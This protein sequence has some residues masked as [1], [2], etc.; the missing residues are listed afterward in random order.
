MINLNPFINLI[1]SALSIY[2]FLLLVYVILQLLF[3]FKIINPYSQFVQAVNRFLIRIIEP[4]LTRMRKYIP[5]MGGIDIAVIVLF[6]LINFL[7]DALH[8]YFYVY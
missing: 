6:L 7:K 5:P 4:V 1:T 3:T 8:T 2:S